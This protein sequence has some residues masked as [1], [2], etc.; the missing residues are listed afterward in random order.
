MKTWREFR[1]PALRRKVHLFTTRQ[2]DRDTIRQS[3]PDFTVARKEWL[4]EGKRLKVFVVNQRNV[5]TPTPCRLEKEEGKHE[6]GVI[7]SCL[8]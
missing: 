5:N 7:D 8:N 6:W 4:V 3:P 2:D 1:F